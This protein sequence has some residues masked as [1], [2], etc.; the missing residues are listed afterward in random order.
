MYLNKT[1]ISFPKENVVLGMFTAV[2]SH[3]NL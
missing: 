1:S 2:V 3:V